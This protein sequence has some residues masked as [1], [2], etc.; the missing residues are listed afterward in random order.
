MQMIAR[1]IFIFCDL[2]HTWC[3]QT[4]F[5]EATADAS[6]T[7]VCFLSVISFTSIASLLILTLKSTSVWKSPHNQLWATCKLLF[8]GRTGKAHRRRQ[9]CN[10]PKREAEIICFIYDLLYWCTHPK[11]SKSNCPN[12]LGAGS[13]ISMSNDPGAMAIWYL[14]KIRE[15]RSHEKWVFDAGRCKVHSSRVLQLLKDEQITS[16]ILSDGVFEMWQVIMVCLILK[17]WL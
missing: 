14:W 15:T 9:R 17:V 1:V 11:G 7:D 8:M 13:C 10:A 5:G 12:N 4:D 3:Y 6:M 2:A 16:H